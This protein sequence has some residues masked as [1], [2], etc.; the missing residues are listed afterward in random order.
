LD[1]KTPAEFANIK[2]PYKN[3]AE[4]IRQPFSKETEIKNHKTP[5]IHLPP[6]PRV[7]LSD[8]HVGKPRKHVRISNKAPRITPKMAKLE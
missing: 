7:K 3:W 2:F 8:T 4:I 5:H 6:K 1:E